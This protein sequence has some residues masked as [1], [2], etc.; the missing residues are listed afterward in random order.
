MFFYNIRL[1]RFLDLP[2]KALINTTLPERM[3]FV[4]PFLI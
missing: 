3:E 4:V 2:S 1:H